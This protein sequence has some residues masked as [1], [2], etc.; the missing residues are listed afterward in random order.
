MTASV[1]TSSRIQAG[2]VSV[3]SSAVA[4]SVSTSS[5]IQA[6]LVSV[7]FKAVAGSVSSSSSV[8]AGYQIFYKDDEF[9][10]R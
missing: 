5:R 6:G 10:I 1:S 4:V 3:L 9:K 7:L 2:L 8:V